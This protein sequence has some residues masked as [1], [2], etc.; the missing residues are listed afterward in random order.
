[1]IING[2]ISRILLLTTIILIF[3]VDINTGQQDKK[4]TLQLLGLFTMSNCTKEHQ[5]KCSNALSNHL[6]MIQIHQQKHDFFYNTAVCTKDIKN[7]SKTLVDF[8]FPVIEEPNM[9]VDGPC[10]YKTGDRFSEGRKILRTVIFTYL[11]FEL[12]RLTS[13]LILP[14]T[15]FLVV[16]VTEQTMYPAYYV[17]NPLYIYS[18]EA[19]FGV[20]IHDKFIKIKEKLNITYTGIF[21]LQQEVPIVNDSRTISQESLKE[22]DFSTNQPI[23][24]FCYYLRAK[25]NECY[26]EINI[27]ANNKTE[28]EIA[29]NQT[30]IHKLSF[31]LLAGDSWAITKFRELSGTS[32]QKMKD[33]FY[34]PFLTESKNISNNV[35]PEELSYDKKTVFSNFPGS[36]AINILLNFVF[37]FA[38]KLM[39]EFNSS[40][41]DNKVIWRGLLKQPLFQAFLKN[42]IRFVYLNFFDNTYKENDDITLDLVLEVPHSLMKDLVSLL[43]KDQRMLSFLVKHY[44]RAYYI[45]N[46]NQD[47]LMNQ[48]TFNPSRALESRPFCNEKK[49]NCSSGQELIHSFYQE[50]YWTRSY[51]WNCQQCKDRFYKSTN[52]NVERC[53]ECF[54]PMRVNNNR[55]SCYDPFFQRSISF[56]DDR[57]VYAI[58]APSILLAA[59]TIFTMILFTVKRNTPIVM[60]ANWK[61]TAIQLTTHLLLFTVP[62][63]IFLSTTPTMCIARQLFLGISFS[64]TISINISKSQKLYMIVGKQVR[65]TKSEIFLTNASEWFVILAVLVINS[66]IHL[67]A[68]INT[69]VIVGTVYHDATLDKEDYCTN[70]LSIFIQ[71]LMATLLSVCNGVQGFRA[72]KLPSQFRET[73]HVIYSSFISVVVFIAST[74]SYFTN[75]KIINRDFIVLLVVLVFNGTH[76]GLLYGYKIGVMIFNPAK[77]TRKAVEK[78]RLKKLNLN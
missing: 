25:P 67:M 77:N 3:K 17:E 78:K 37:N 38:N 61:M 51:G 1:M 44:K 10:D 71:L 8:L 7:S 18:Y 28:I 50:Q 63:F 75:K 39:D 13:A 26:K 64:I 57:I 19:S 14:T 45:Q 41:K 4:D 22:C 49:P 42:N 47:K 31:I 9:I 11:S 56:A 21:N 69:D 20:N 59:L 24:A 53:Q 29:I 46:V 40:N 2:I 60:S 73:N 43:M 12:T 55:T 58:V 5:F 32:E 74:A 6:A 35:L 16:S 66:L 48:H 65:M 68:F 72:R 27:N 34:L 76:F 23:T 30:K 54:Y 52:G 36:R 70:D 15:N 62:I 33:I